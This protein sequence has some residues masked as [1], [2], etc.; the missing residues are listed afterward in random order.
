MDSTNYLPVVQYPG[1]AD[2][3]GTPALTLGDTLK[4]AGVRLYNY[5][6]SIQPTISPPGTSF[7]WRVTNVDNSVYLDKPSSYTIYFGD[8]IGDFYSMESEDGVIKGVTLWYP[9][10]YQL[11]DDIAITRNYIFFTSG[12]LINNAYQTQLQRIDKNTVPVSYPKDVVEITSALDYNGV[13]RQFNFSSIASDS[14]FIP[15]FDCS[16][17]IYAVGTFSTDLNNTY[18]VRAAVDETVYATPK[19]VTKPITTT[20][21]SVI[22]TIPGLGNVSKIAMR[23]GVLYFLWSDP[24]TTITT[25]R[26]VDFTNWYNRTFK[27]LQTKN[28]QY[29]LNL[30]NVSKGLTLSLGFGPYYKITVEE[31]TASFDFPTYYTIKDL[32]GANVE[33]P[34]IANVAVYSCLAID[35]QTNLYVTFPQPLATG[36]VIAYSVYVYQQ[37]TSYDTIAQATQPVL[38]TQYDPYA[39]KYS[40]INTNKT[41]AQSLYRYNNQPIPFAG[42]ICVEPAYV[43][44]TPALPNAAYAVFRNIAGY[45]AMSINYKTNTVYV[46]DKGNAIRYISLRTGG[47]GSLLEL[48]GYTYQG[49]LYNPLTK[50][51][52]LYTVPTTG[53]KDL[54][55]FSGKKFLSTHSPIQIRPVALTIVPADVY[56]GSLGPRLVGNPAPI[57]APGQTTGDLT[58]QGK[59]Y[60]EWSYFK[61]V[62][63]VITDTNILQLSFKFH[64]TPVRVADGAPYGRPPPPHSSL[65]Y[66]NAYVYANESRN[67]ML[68]QFK[69]TVGYQNPI[70]DITKS[71]A[72][73]SALKIKTLTVEALGYTVGSIF[74]DDNSLAYR[75]I[76]LGYQYT[77]TSDSTFS[78]PVLRVV[79]AF[80]RQSAIDYGYFTPYDPLDGFLNFLNGLWD[81]LYGF[82]APIISL[83]VNLFETFQAI[84]KGQSIARIGW[85][86]VNV[87][88]SVYDVAGIFTPLRAIP[89]MLGIVTGSVNAA[90]N[91]GTPGLKGTLFAAGNVLLTGYEGY[92]L[93]TTGN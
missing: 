92:N 73:S 34:I 19:G 21:F 74:T 36:D 86:F 16:G 88:M 67:I 17:F 50:T 14:D 28:Y 7:N 55:T 56:A 53:P 79:G 11:T 6:S 83:A 48:A 32:S 13:A 66:Y 63:F 12:K 26:Y 35:S 62:K 44:N 4:N 65:V 71:F 64:Y 37:I 69:G 10:T 84:A 3:R 24:M 29:N 2:Q 72:L 70:I 93:A 30:N 76:T 40:T 8:N 31:Y 81:F 85:G 78:P 15:S 27:D 60:Y 23:K 59:K 22:M 87:I 75:L 25:I 41:T 61:D 9:Y 38:L 42:N 43:D 80:P 45:G 58:G 33:V 57:P 5:V 18:I 39:N 77:I 49:N 91:F 52:D 54:I 90:V 51:Y 82:I 46:A 20:E 68:F 1:S 89:S 47:G